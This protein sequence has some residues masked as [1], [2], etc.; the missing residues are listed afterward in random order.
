MNWYE[1]PACN[2]RGVPKKIAW[3]Q[4]HPDEWPRVMS[5]FWLEYASDGVTPT[6]TSCWCTKT[7]CIVRYCGSL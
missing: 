5:V 6:R 2:S 4:T 1:N 3:M 7:A